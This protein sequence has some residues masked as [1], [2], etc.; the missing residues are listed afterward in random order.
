MLPPRSP[1]ECLGALYVV[2]GSTLGGAMIGRALAPHFGDACRFFLGHDK[3]LW[4]ELLASLEALVG[5][6]VAEV[7]ALGAA[8]ATFSAFEI[9]MSGG[10]QHSLAQAPAGGRTDRLVN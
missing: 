10:S 1:A 6:R 9:W 7:A 4:R 3:A 5:D 8:A 2:E